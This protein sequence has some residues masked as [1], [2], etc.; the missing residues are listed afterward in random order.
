MYYNEEK[1]KQ[2]NFSGSVITK[3][4]VFSDYTIS[5]W[6]DFADNDILSSFYFEFQ[7]ICEDVRSAKN[8]EVI[9]NISIEKTGENYKVTLNDLTFCCDTIHMSIEKYKGFSYRNMYDTDEYRK[10][11]EKIMYAEDEKYFCE[12]KEYELSDGY[13]VNYKSYVDDYENENGT[14]ITR[15]SLLK[16]SLKKSG[17]ILYEC[18]KNSHMSK[19]FS[20]FIYHSNGHRY[21]PFKVDLYGIS[22]I[23]VDTLEVY[24][25]IPEGYEHD[26]SY[27]CG[28]SF[29]IT[30]IHYDRESNLIAYGGC[31][32]AGPYYVVVGDFSNPLAFNPHLVKLYDIFDIYE[33]E[34]IYLDD[35]DFIEWKNGRLYVKCYYESFTKEESISI[36]ELKD[37]INKLTKGER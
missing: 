29:I 37:M 5:I 19:P 21:H 17:N 27:P 6:G 11:I 4:H 26:Y 31:Y 36:E 12:E 3:I 1:F 30:D 22:Y 34:E 10:S 23:D 28:E 24:N 35:V 16:C 15:A 32:W 20:E 33:D 9:E 14:L 13:S 7:H 2:C 25:Y 8:W 18:Y